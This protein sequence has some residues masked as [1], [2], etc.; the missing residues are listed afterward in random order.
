MNW[1]GKTSSI[2]GGAQRIKGATTFSL[3]K[4]DSI[5]LT[6]ILTWRRNWWNVITARSARARFVV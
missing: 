6:W 2:V 4:K 5:D 3:E 1:I